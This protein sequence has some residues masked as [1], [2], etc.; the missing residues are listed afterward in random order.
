M[1]ESI[2]S[3]G[4]A[5]RSPW[6]MVILGFLISSAA[7]WL[8]FFLA[9]YIP[10]DL[11]MLVLVITVIALAP[12]LHRIFVIEEIE[13]EH[14]NHNHPLGFI[15]RHVDVIAMYSFLFVGLLASF[16]FW[17]VML[18]HSGEVSSGEFFS[19][20]ES[21]VPSVRQQITGKAT[22]SEEPG[23]RGAIFGR[24]YQNNLQVMGYCFLA[25]LLFGAGAVWIMSWNASVIA[26][27][28][29][30]VIK[31]NLAGMS[32]IEAYFVGFP[33][34]SLSM[35]AWAIPEVLAYLAAAF[36]GGILSVAVSRHH[37]GSEKFWV[38]VFDA[39]IFM[40]IAILLVFV[41]AYVEHFFV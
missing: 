12:L 23:F 40:L 8:G 5:E 35:A 33:T 18:P 13:E 32:A 9:N 2:L 6:D 39:V 34:Y 7:L 22:A 16:T 4:T 37:F 15:L 21:T 27:S 24:L 38:T 19:L 25:S 3:P 17:Y 11:S 28:I 30:S 36:A 31:T 14:S 41:G 20:Q 29:G 1:L 10:A 26:V